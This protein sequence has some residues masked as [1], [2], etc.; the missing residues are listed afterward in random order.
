MQRG[1]NLS[2]QSRAEQSRA[3]QS[4]ALTIK[5]FFVMSYFGQDNIKPPGNKR[6]FRFIPWR[7]FAAV[8]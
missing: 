2:E 6:I 8:S 4:R 1:D 3:E 7:F 5:L